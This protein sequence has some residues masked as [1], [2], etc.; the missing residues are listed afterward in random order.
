MNRD[1]RNYDESSKADKF[2]AEEDHTSLINDSQIFDGK[3]QTTDGE[4]IQS[5]LRVNYDN[6]NIIRILNQS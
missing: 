4:Y 3:I 6:Q 5:Y 2:L 1:N